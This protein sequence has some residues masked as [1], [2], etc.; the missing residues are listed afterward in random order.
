MLEDML[1]E[2]HASLEFVDTLNDDD[3][4]REILLRCF[5][6]MGRLYVR[7]GTVVATMG[8]FLKEVTDVMSE[9]GESP[10]EKQLEI[11]AEKCGIT[12]KMAKDHEWYESHKHEIQAM[13]GKLIARARQLALPK[14]GLLEDR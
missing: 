8:T 14:P 9:T 6:T 2:L 1:I 3:K 12:N 13:D 5:A 10:D 7:T 11:I 4:K